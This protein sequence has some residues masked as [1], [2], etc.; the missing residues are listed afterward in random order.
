[1]P[2][3]VREKV[4]HVHEYE[5]PPKL[6]VYRVIWEKNYNHPGDRVSHVVWAPDDFT[7]RELV[8]RLE[9]YNGY[10]HACTFVM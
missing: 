9:T 3:I 8:A 2:V 10:V 1:V 4:V 5:Q 6:N 7:A